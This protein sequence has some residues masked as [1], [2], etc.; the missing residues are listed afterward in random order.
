MI[1]ALIGVLLLGLGAGTLIGLSLQGPKT[2]QVT[3]VP[4][5]G[6]YKAHVATSMAPLPVL[7]R[8]TT[9]FNATVALVCPGAGLPTY[10]K[11]SYISPKALLTC[12]TVG[13][14]NIRDGQ[15]RTVTSRPY[16]LDPGNTRRLTDPTD[17]AYYRALLKEGR[18]PTSGSDP[19]R[20]R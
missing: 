9:D 4:S 2:T 10:P 6:G 3:Y 15:S 18:F 19:G 7:E 20:P 12:L 14:Q 16:S 17:T 5:P 8:V 11:D 1:Q 13:A